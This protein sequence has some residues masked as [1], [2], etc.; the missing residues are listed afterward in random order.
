M[1]PKRFLSLFFFD[2]PRNDHSK[3]L[4][5]SSSLRDCPFR[6]DLFVSNSRLWL[7]LVIRLLSIEIDFFDDWLILFIPLYLN[8][9][10]VSFMIFLFDHLR[11]DF[12]NLF[13]L[14]LFLLSQ[15]QVYLFKS[16][17]RLLFYFSVNKIIISTCKLFKMIWSNLLIAKIDRVQCIFWARLLLMSKTTIMISSSLLEWFIISLS[18]SIQRPDRYS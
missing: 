13:I 7:L 8:Y 11:F 4:R 16:N 10:I 12:F 3:R 18:F 1:K 2:F 15:S 6:T 17:L 9:L 14:S 5:S